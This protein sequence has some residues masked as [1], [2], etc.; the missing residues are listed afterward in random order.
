MKKKDS[1]QQGS[2]GQWNQQGQNP[3]WQQGPGPQPGYQPAP[4][5]KKPIYK[6]VWFWLLIVVIVVIAIAVNQP[7]D[8]S[9]NGE[10]VT[11]DSSASSTT[12]GKSATAKKEETKSDKP[13]D[14]LTLEK[15]WKFHKDPYVPYVTGTVHN[16]TDQ[17]INTY[18]EITFDALDGD[19]A[20]VGTCLA[21]TETIDAN[22]NW[23]FKAICDGD[24]IKT[25]RLKELSGF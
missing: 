24:N 7:K 1:G 16:N 20:N 9:Q 22:G 11:A 12:A 10:S 6:R 15:G 13:A 21:N 23:K 18:V 4:S 3:Q 14:K 2:Q 5:K 17:E 8:N 25:V 19:G